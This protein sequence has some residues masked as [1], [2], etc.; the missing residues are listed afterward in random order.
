[1]LGPARWGHIARLYYV[2]FSQPDLFLSKPWEILAIWHGGLGIL[3]A[4][5]GGFLV[6]LWYCRKK[7]LSLWRLADVLAPCMILGQATGILGCLATGLRSSAVRSGVFPRPS[8]NAWTR[9]AG[10][11]GVW[12]GAPAGFGSGLVLFGPI[13][14]EGTAPM[15][16]PLGWRRG[17]SA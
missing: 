16:P 12:P 6:A 5:A 17:G 8:G 11:S 3:G 14:A 15:R 2:V 1:M 13:G 4:L 7:K 10:G 9:P